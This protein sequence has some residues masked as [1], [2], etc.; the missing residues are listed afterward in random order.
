MW[1][2]SYLGI[3]HAEFDLNRP[4]HVAKVGYGRLIL[5]FKCDIAPNSHT[6]P[7]MHEVAFIEELW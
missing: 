2:T 6:S 5:L 7:E 1:R 3:P 4:E